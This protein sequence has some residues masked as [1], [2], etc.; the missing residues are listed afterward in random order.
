MPLHKVWNRL[1]GEGER[2]KALMDLRKTHRHR[3]VIHLQ[4]QVQ[5][6]ETKRPNRAEEYATTTLP[7]ITVYTRRS[8][9]LSTVSWLS[10]ARAVSLYCGSP[11]SAVEASVIV[12]LLALTHSGTPNTRTKT[13]TAAPGTQTDTP[14]IALF[15]PIE[16]SLVRSH[17]YF[18]VQ[19][20]M[21]T[22][23]VRQ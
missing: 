14:A 3:P 12:R 22:R 10:E 13:S 21:S 15:T 18:R 8:P 16:Q 23:S 1:K 7:M 5:P 2:G 4:I 11:C 19:I 6:G 9:D 20:S 17:S